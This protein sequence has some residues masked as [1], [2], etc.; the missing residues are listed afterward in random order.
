MSFKKLALSAAILAISYSAHASKEKIDEAILGVW[1]MFPLANGIANVVE[2]KGNGEVDN[3][4]FR[5]DIASQNVLSKGIETKKYKLDG[6]KILFVTEGTPEF[7]EHL[8]FKGIQT[9]KM[10][11][12]RL[13]PI[14]QLTQVITYGEDEE[15]AL[16]FEYLQRESNDYTPLCDAYFAMQ[17]AGK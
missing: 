14:L 10:R 3:H 7:K 8:I 9:R 12:G 5:C 16:D 13:Y 1:A 6:N 4:S 17:K 11:S 15:L 2:F